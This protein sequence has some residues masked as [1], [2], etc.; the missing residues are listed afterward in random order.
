MKLT[1]NQLRAFIKEQ[2]EDNFENWPEHSKQQFDKQVDDIVDFGKFSLTINMGNDAMNDKTRAS[3][4]ETLHN[5]ADRIVSARGGFVKGEVYDGK[6]GN[7][8][9]SWKIGK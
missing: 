6:N 7:K 4:T 5:L 1:I 8:V 3:L 9:G 2:V